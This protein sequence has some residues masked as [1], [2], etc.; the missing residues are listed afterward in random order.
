[1][2]KNVIYIH[3]KQKNKTKCAYTNKQITLSLENV[4]EICFHMNF[5]S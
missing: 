4:H 2:K 5:L 1:M 3:E